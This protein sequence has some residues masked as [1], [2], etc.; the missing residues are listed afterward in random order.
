MPCQEMYLFR[1]ELKRN[2]FRLLH[3]VELVDD[4][5]GQTDFLHRIGNRL[6]YFLF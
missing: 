3:S 4:V 6:E 1:P 5:S 2:F